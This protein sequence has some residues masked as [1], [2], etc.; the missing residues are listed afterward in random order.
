MAVNCSLTQILV[1]HESTSEVMTVAD[2]KM[3][4]IQAVAPIMTYIL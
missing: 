4:F 3:E 2:K 1:L